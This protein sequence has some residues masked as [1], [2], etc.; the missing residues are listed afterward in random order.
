MSEKSGNSPAPADKSSE[1]FVMHAATE[2]QSLIRELAGPLALGDRVKAALARV[3]RLTGLSERRV[4]GLYHR[5]ARAIR[6][7]E[8]DTLRRE[9]RRRREEEAARADFRDATAV[10]R[11]AVDRLAQAD[12][13]FAGPH[14]DALGAAAPAPCR[15]H[16][17]VDRG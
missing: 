17:P 1:V 11:V 2:A 13:D 4:R 10:Y 3:A 9:A 8:L 16:R 5:E 7:E 12:A 14:A 6:A 15:P